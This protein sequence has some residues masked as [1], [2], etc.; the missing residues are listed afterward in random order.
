MVTNA[1]VARNQRI[2]KKIGIF[3]H[4]TV[5]TSKMQLQKKNKYAATLIKQADEQGQWDINVYRTDYQGQPFFLFCKFKN[6]ISNRRF[7]Y[8]DT[9]YKEYPIAT[10]IN[11]Y[12]YINSI[13]RSIIQNDEF[14]FYLNNSA[15][16]NEIYYEV[17]DHYNDFPI[18]RMDDESM[19]FNS[20]ASNYITG[21]IHLNQTDSQYIQ[22][23]SIQ[24]VQGKNNYILWDD[25]QYPGVYNII[26]I[27]QIVKIT[28]IDYSVIDHISVFDVNGDSTEIY[29]D[30]VYRITK[31]IPEDVSSYCILCSITL[32]DGLT[33]DQIYP[34]DFRIELLPKVV[35]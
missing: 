19:T 1:N 22:V 32:V 34:V 27:D 11:G 7:I 5:S 24:K 17:T 15:D 35:K 25:G 20:T 30:G 31:D 2:F 13:D 21:K 16:K 10:L 6:A 3:E 26:H 12:N 8:T 23:D 18:N 14:S 33:N 4:A 9:S 29:E 28:G